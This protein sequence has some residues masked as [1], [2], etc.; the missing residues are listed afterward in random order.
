MITV[1]DLLQ[2][3]KDSNHIVRLVNAGDTWDKY[4]EFRINSPFL[5]EFSTW[6]V[7]KIRADEKYCI[8]VE[9]SKSE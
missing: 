1:N 5:S 2:S 4:A 8:K 9:I 3:F 7:I 6:N